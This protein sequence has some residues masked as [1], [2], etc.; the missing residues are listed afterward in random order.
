MG[1]RLPSGFR[2]KASALGD[3]DP[4]LEFREGRSPPP[5]GPV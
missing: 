4:T 5:E 1:H 2:E 3:H